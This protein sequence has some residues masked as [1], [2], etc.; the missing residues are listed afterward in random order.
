MSG[1]PFAVEAAFG[2]LFV[3]TFITWLRRRDALSRDVMLIFATLAGLFFVTAF[4]AGRTDVPQGVGGVALALLLAQP[5]LT[6][7][8][9][10]RIRRI[11]RS[12]LIAAVVVWAVTAL[13]PIFV[14]PRLVWPLLLGGLIA[15]IVMDIAAAVYFWLEARK[16]VAA[17]RARLTAAAAASA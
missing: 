14:S 2:L 9:V 17:A 1:L 7:R 5:V 4:S 12:V 15:F 10:A 6:L 13:P 3:A 11:R 16:R 8:L